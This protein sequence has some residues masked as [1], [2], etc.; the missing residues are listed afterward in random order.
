AYMEHYQPTAPE[1]LQVIPPLL[2]PESECVSH[3]PVHGKIRMVYAGALYPG[4]RTPDAALSWLEAVLAARLDWRGKLELHWYGVVRPEHYDAVVAKPWIVL[5]GLQPRA[6]V[7]RALAA[8][9][10]LLHL[11]NRSEFQLPSKA[12][13]YLAA[14]RPVLHF[15][16]VGRDPVLAFWPTDIPCWTIR[17]GASTGD[18]LSSAIQFIENARDTPTACA[19]AAHYHRYL[20]ESIGKQYLDFAVG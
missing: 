10:L 11:G 3:Q 13:D 2:W 19:L 1:N 14:G 4:L 20:P 8:A 5:H 18:S 12:V 16:Y 17:V 7:R 6:T 15:Q 9:D